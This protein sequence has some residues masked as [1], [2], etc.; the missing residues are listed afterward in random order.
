MHK[1]FKKCL[2][3]LLS[4]SMLLGVAA[5][6]PKPPFDTET[7]PVDTTEQ[8]TEA[9]TDPPIPEVDRTKP[10]TGPFSTTT[11]LSFD[12]QSTAIIEQVVT[13]EY[14]FISA[15]ES[16][17]I[18]GIGEG[19]SKGHVIK[20]NPKTVANVNIGVSFNEGITAK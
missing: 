19:N 6:T 7:P 13:E 10:Q 14:E 17:T 2:I 4:A 12:K 9:V 3:Y 18:F 15:Q 16:G 20:L 1:R 11:S 8:P 5:C